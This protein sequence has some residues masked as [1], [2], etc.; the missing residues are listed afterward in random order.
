MDVDEGAG[1]RD[2]PMAPQLQPPSAT[3]PGLLASPLRF[4]LPATSAGARTPVGAVTPRSAAG[5]ADALLQ[6]PTGSGGWRTPGTDERRRLMAPNQGA[7]LAGLGPGA[8]GSSPGHTNS[9]SEVPPASWSDWNKRANGFG[10]VSSVAGLEGAASTPDNSRRAIRRMD[11]GPAAGG[12]GALGVVLQGWW[13][14]D[15]RR[16]CDR[17]TGAAHYLTSYEPVV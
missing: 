11:G 16:G 10:I 14:G 9:W 12:V 6:S 3:C 1:T 4:N 13:V 17:L 7:G 2:G 15:G 8:L 5:R